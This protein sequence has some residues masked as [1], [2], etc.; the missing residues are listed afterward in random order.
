M[1]HVKNSFLLLALVSLSFFMS[2]GP[3]DSNEP[4]DQEVLVS[5]ITSGSWSV[6]SSSST[7]NVTGSPTLDDLTID[8][9]D[10]GNGVIN[11]TLGGAISAFIS[12]GT[13]TINEDGTLAAVSTSDITLGK[14]DISVSSATITASASEVKVTVVTAEASSRISGVG[15]YTLV[16]TSGS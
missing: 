1:K 2:C 15:T 13:F 9:A 4:S 16:F 14:T 5:A 8:F 7:S 6:S 10:Q 12:G 3:D 11:F